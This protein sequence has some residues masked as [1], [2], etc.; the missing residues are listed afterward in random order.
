VSGASLYISKGFGRFAS[1]AEIDDQS[2]LDIASEVENG[3]VDADLGGALF[4][5]RV[6]RKGQG[7]SSGYRVI[8]IFKREKRI[9]FIYGFPKSSK[10]TLSPK[11]LRAFKHLADELL[12]LS[13]DQMKKAVESGA[14]RQ[15][16]R[17]EK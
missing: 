14:F 3:Q 17:E 4:K 1:D 5:K 12:D 15:L 6:R 16:P 13:E 8:V 10:A 2:L 7:K 9:F 11:E